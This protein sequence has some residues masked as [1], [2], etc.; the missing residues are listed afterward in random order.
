MSPMPAPLE[1]LDLTVQA[2]T[3]EALFIEAARGMVNLAGARAKRGVLIR[4]AV[5]VRGEDAASLLLAWL[6]QLLA[7]SELEDRVFYDFSIVSLSALRLSAQA[8]GGLCE[9]I[10]R[11]LTLELGLEISL[12]QTPEG[13]TV[14]IPFQTPA[15]PP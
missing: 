13:Y 14:T 1:R 5:E 6:R 12:R 2:P 7:Y 8:V 15:G 9:Q 11:P 4:R 10:A 3:L